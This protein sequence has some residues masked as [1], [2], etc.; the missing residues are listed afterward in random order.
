MGDLRMSFLDRSRSAVS[1]S[2]GSR[3][4]PPRSAPHRE[5]GL[6]DVLVGVFGELVDATPETLPSAMVAGLEAMARCLD[7]D[8]AGVVTIDHDRASMELLFEW[9]SERMPEGFVS[10]ASL[11]L[12]AQPVWAEQVRRLEPVFSSDTRILGPELAAERA[13][14]E[15]KGIGATAEIP[16]TIGG[17]LHGLVFFDDFQGPRRWD[18]AEPSLRLFADIL[19]SALERHRVDVALRDSERR[20]RLIADNSSDVIGLV[21]ATSLVLYASPACER[22]LGY[23]PEDLVGRRLFDIS[24]PDDVAHALERAQ[25]LTHTDETVRFEHRIIRGDDERA[26]WVETLARTTERDEA[27]RILEI[28]CIARDVTERRRTAEAIEHLAFHD[29]LTGLPNRA[30]F[31]DRLHQALA[32]IG[33]SDETLALLFLDLDRFK[34]VNDSLGHDVGDALLTAVAERL[35]SSVRGGDTAA[36]YGGDEFVVLCEPI[37]TELDAVAVAERITT[38]MA[39]PV[40]IDG[41]LVQA[42]FSIGVAVA[43]AGVDVAELL[44]Q[45]DLAVA[46]AKERG[47]NRYELFDAELR[48]MADHRRAV[49]KGLHRAV[50]DHEFVVVYQPIADEQTGA[51]VGFEALVRWEHPEQGLL[52]P[53]T[54]LPIADETGLIVP[55]ADRVLREA[56]EQ[57]GDWQ[58]RHGRSFAMHVNLAAR[59]L[60]DQGFVDALS[61]L[62]DDAPVE[63]GGLCLEVTEATLSRDVDRSA[64]T[65]ARVRGLGVDVAIDDFGTGSSS[66]SLLRRFPVSQLKIDQ[67]VISELA[68]SDPGSGVVEALVDLGHVLGLD[69]VAEGVESTEHLTALRSLGCDRA[70]GYWLSKPLPA[71]E[72]DDLLLAGAF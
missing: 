3:P 5:D 41:R 16:L 23:T 6:L 43:T 44:Q 56:V 15:R 65:L 71:A 51:V 54:F 14:Q 52:M 48:A 72:I 13:L 57:L 50:H 31:L 47:R 1:V 70:Q 67:A 42:S 10:E 40:M 37:H 7:V 29:A 63:P 24:H 20:Y 28:Q 66:L 18:A 27:G 21:D 26:V 69:V 61:R 55:I 25:E 53:S 17:R 45:A 46:H 59:Q 62:L 35:R 49:E 19:A 64:E 32:R 33:R 30:L 60:D 12:A 58:R 34:D 38:A 39:E 9:R 8:R 4:R 68:S 22:L 36:R 2:T 11:P